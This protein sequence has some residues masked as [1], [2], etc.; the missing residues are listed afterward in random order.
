MSWELAW[1]QA[2][3]VLC[4]SSHVLERRDKIKAYVHPPRSPLPAPSFLLFLLELLTLWCFVLKLL[5]L[6]FL[7]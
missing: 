6:V 7:F 3:L 4:C 1:S 5:T 2:G